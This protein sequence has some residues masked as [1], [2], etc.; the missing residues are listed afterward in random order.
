MTRALD[1]S[2]LLPEVLSC[3]RAA[4][5]L[6][7]EASGAPRPP[8]RDAAAHAGDTPEAR[9]RQAS[10]E[11]LRQGLA[12]LLPGVPV[13]D[14]GARGRTSLWWCVDPLGGA[15]ELARG[16][17][18]FTVDVGLVR[19]HRPVLGVVHVPAR[20]RTYCGAIDHGAYRSEATGLPVPI[21][22][23]H[24]DP[25][26]LRIISGR[27]QATPAHAAMN[28]RVYMA[29]VRVASQRAGS[30]LPLC[31][32]AEGSADLAPWTVSAHGAAP[33]AA[34]AVLE[35]AGGRLTDLFGRSPRYAAS[36]RDLDLVASGDPDLDW[37]RYTAPVARAMPATVPAWAV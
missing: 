31:R 11:V 7:L 22:V 2:S 8:C 9:A 36:S 27:G 23:R 19:G 29:G 28:R 37:Q 20:G 35:A 3:A 33:A 16:T 32:V 12:R 24:A 25:C 15:E 10:G 1:P 17:G 21:R 14:S 6:V 26:L 5:A 30:T 18:L 34:H 4:G 13:L